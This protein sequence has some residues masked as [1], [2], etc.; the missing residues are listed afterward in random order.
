M[1]RSA[2]EHGANDSAPERDGNGDTERP[3]VEVVL[4]LDGLVGTG[5]DDRIEAEEQAA[6]RAGHGTFAEQDHGS[7][8]R[9]RH[10]GSGDEK[11][12]GCGENDI[13]L[14]GRVSCG[15]RSG[16]V[17]AKQIRCR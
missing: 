15:E 5:D 11:L 10:W 1:S 8:S 2:A 13:T 6:E 7:V 12:S 9:G 14:R 4:R 16:M 3:T 17:G